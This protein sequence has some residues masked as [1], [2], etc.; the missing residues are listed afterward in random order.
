[1]EASSITKWV[2]ILG[3]VGTLISGVNWSFE[4]DKRTG[5]EQ[6]K[7]GLKIVLSNRS[8]K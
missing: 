7:N 5:V 3:A 4:Y 1:M 6:E 8:C 2:A